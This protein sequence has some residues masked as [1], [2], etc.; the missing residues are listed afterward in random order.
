MSEPSLPAL[1]GS[2]VLVPVKAFSHAKERLAPSLAP[3]QRGELA[4]VMAEHV[5]RAASPLPAAVVCDDETVAQ[6]AAAHDAIVL[7]EPG[8]GLNGAV[9][10]GVAKLVGA[11]AEEVVVAHGDLPLAHSLSHLTGFMGITLVP[12]RRGDGTNVLCLP[13]GQPFRFSYGPGS[14]TRHAAEARRLGLALRTLRE[15]DLAWDVD[16]P[17]DIPVGLVPFA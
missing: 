5:L 15:P 3:A 17:A 16:E 13:A 12:D 2:V 1:S 6:W 9:E 10:A 11:G 8:R 7:R 4:R 14:Y